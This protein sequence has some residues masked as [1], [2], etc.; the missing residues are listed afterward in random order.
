[1]FKVRTVTVPPVAAGDVLIRVEAAG[2]NRPD[3]MLR[4][5]QYPLPPGANVTQIS[6]SLAK[7]RPSDVSSEN[8]H[9]LPGDEDGGAG[10]LPKHRALVAITIANNV[11]FGAHEVPRGSGELGAQKID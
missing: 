2:V 9:H 1:M 5:G 11:R 4:L 6:K 3:V 7:S 8:R 10:S